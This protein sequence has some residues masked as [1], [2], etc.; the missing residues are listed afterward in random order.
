MCI[1]S[2]LTANDANSTNYAKFTRA[3]SRYSPFRVIR[4][5]TPHREYR[6]E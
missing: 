5:S 3:F 1:T 6:E 2:F 4:D